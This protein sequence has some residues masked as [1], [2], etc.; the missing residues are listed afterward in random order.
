MN[1]INF[2]SSGI[3][4]LS[5]AYVTWKPY[6]QHIY[7]IQD[8]MHNN[9]HS[10]ESIQCQSIFIFNKSTYLITDIIYRSR[11][12]FSSFIL[13]NSDIE[14]RYDTQLW[15]K[16]LNVSQNG[17]VIGHRF[18][19]SENWDDGCINFNGIDFFL[20]N[21]LLYIPPDNTFAIGLCSWDWWLPYLAIQQKIPIYRI[22]SPLLYHKR[23]KRKWDNESY[24]YMQ[25]HFFN[26]TGY[27]SCAQY[28]K[29]IIDKCIDI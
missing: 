21:T 24:N 11:E 8:T 13:L 16:I 5:N 26:L 12:K 23:H 27:D 3:N 9:D 6:A 25:K 15:N 22:T 28:K 10:L 4:S 7:N 20:I 17:F 18:N 19:Y 1:K 14:L 29:L 2:V